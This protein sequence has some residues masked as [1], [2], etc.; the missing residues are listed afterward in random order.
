M[1]LRINQN[2]ISLKT[3][4]V[5]A[6]TSDRLEKSIEKLSSGLRINRAADD[7]AGL[8]ISEK[9]RRQIRGLSRAVLNAQDGISMI[10]TGEGAL[11]ESHSILQRMRELAIQS[12]NDTLTSNDRL[13]IQKEVVQ[14]RDDLNRI[15]HNTEFNTKK[16]LDG[17]QTALFSSSSQAV[18]GLVVTDGVTAGDSEVSIALITGGISQMQRSQIFTLKDN[19]STLASGGT[20][21][22]SIGQFYDTNGVFV[23]ESPMAVTLSGSS[24]TTSVTIDGQMTL[25]KLAAVL[26][27]ALVGS[28]GL[29][30]T[31]TKVSVVNTA[32]SSMAGVGGYLQLI[33][34]SIGENG[35]V[36]IAADQTVQNA[37]GFAITRASKNNL[38]EVT[39]RDSFGSITRVRTDSDRVTGLLNGIDIKFTSQA[40]QVAGTNGLQ[41]G[42]RLSVDQTFTISVGGVP[43]M[44]LAVTISNGVASSAGYT[45]EGIARSMNAQFATVAV[46]TGLNAT[47]VGG[48]I[49]ISYNR[50]ATAAASV[51]TNINITGATLGAATIGLSDGTYA[52]FVDAVKDKNFSSW[53]FNKYFDS[54]LTT[55]SSGSTA[56]FTLS[57]GNGGTITALAFTTIG[58]ASLTVPDMV[59]FSNFQATVNEQLNAATIGMR[60]DQIGGAIAF[61]STRVGKENVDGAAAISS[62]V[63]FKTSGSES[64]FLRNAIWNQFGIMDGTAKGSGDKNFMVHIVAEDPQFQIGADQG[65]AMRVSLSNMSAEALG[66][67]NLDMTSIAGSATALGRINKAIDK[68]SGERSKLGA[69]Q[70]RLEYAINNLRTTSSNLTSAESR[71]RDTDIAAEMIEFTR[72]QIVS[73]SGTAMLAQANLVPQ[74]VLQLLR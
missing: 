50:P 7:A 43:G 72:N 9:L 45:M 58:S 15:A 10:Q 67:D 53:G 32:Q 34:G 29:G 63:S 64:L 71:I 17:S 59:F 23:L 74:G 73:Q 8:A 28:T 42:L 65:Q 61:T 36:A 56:M 38:V 19:A 37:L 6:G 41:E 69:F 33:S 44:S 18:K 30:M 22:Q 52:G 54:G 66:V 13:E 3:Q 39:Q 35:N 24:K 49:R 1:S 26:Q 68:V 55:I 4:G 70:N 51:S 31:N 27:S 2:V 60:V 25:D 62:L 12:S 57:D 16:L 11:N 20:Q 47:V 21:L 46:L 40:A 48:E 14:L 5:L